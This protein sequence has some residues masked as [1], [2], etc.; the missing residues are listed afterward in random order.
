MAGIDEF[1]KLCLHMDGDIA[2]NHAITFN[3]G[4]QYGRRSGKWSLGYLAFDAASSQDVLIADAA[5]LEYDDEW[6]CEMWVKL[7][8][9]TGAK[10]FLGRYVD[11]SNDFELW[12]SSTNGL[13]CYIN[14]GGTT[15]AAGDEGDV[16]DWDT[17]N[18]HH[19]CVQIHNDSGTWKMRVYHNGT[20]VG[21]DATKGSAWSGLASDWRIA[22]YNSNYGTFGVCDFRIQRGTIPYTWAG[23][24]APNAALVAD[25][26]TSILLPFEGDAS[27]SG[28]AFT[29]IST[30][31]ASLS[32]KFDQAFSF[33]GSHYL[34]IADSDD[35]DLDGVDF[36]I[37]FW[38]NITS[39]PGGGGPSMIIGQWGDAGS[40]GSW[41]VDLNGSGQF[42]FYWSE[43]GASES[44]YRW[45]HGISTGSW[46]HFA[47]TYDGTYL[48]SF[49]DGS[50]I[51]EENVGTLTIYN[52]TRNLNIASYKDATTWTLNGLLDEVRISKGTARWTSSFTPPTVAYSLTTYSRYA[53]LE[54]ERVALGLSLRY[55]EMDAERIALGLSQAIAAVDAERSAMMS[56]LARLDAERKAMQLGI[57]QV[58]ALR[59]ALNST[60]AQIDALR[61]APVSQ[62]GYHVWD[63]TTAPEV[64]LGFVAEGGGTLVG[65]SLPDGE[66]ILEVRTSRWFWEG[67]RG[68]RRFVVNASSGTPIEVQTLPVISGL[69][70][71]MYDGLTE[72]AFTASTGYGFTDVQ[73]QVFYSATS[74]VPVT[75][76]PDG[77]IPYLE[78]RGAYRITLPID[79]AGYVAVRAVAGLEIG[80]ATESAIVI[81]GVPASPADQDA[82]PEIP[83]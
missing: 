14:E 37:D 52:S 13:I 76:T 42:D 45:N 34:R 43:D 39:T 72:V 20:A 83:A 2:G 74:P 62:A 17:T 49:V 1:T 44:Y 70:A 38:L 81:V 29:L 65:V 53:M 5:D 23:F 69:T 54:A 33:P 51:G 57:G 3:G 22:N 71:T 28:H 63:V 46:H 73:F 50:L 41:L 78:G 79:A 80:S 77:L 75:G 18:W 58:D 67:C 24:T 6:S 66:R 16:D 40:N 4:V 27:A 68:A 26:D 19:V 21:S 25:G 7:S 61:S 55:A 47:I 82:I 10:F 36:A 9:L 60:I 35:F 56:A 31:T 64:Y 15:Y 32:G 59:L 30:P 48:R 11:A 8:S 12:W